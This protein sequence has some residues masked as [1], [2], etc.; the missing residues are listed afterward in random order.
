MLKIK[1]NDQ[2]RE[3]ERLG[4]EKTTE[5]FVDITDENGENLAHGADFD[6]EDSSAT[7]LLEFVDK[8]VKR[9]AVE[10]IK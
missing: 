9:G 2:R 7:I 8:L 5:G 6:Y 3:R 10:I 1:I 4:G